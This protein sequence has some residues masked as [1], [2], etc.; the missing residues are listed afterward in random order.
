MNFKIKVKKAALEIL[1]QEV[2]IEYKAIEYQDQ[3]V[4]GMN[5]KIK[6]QTTPM[7]MIRDVGYAGIIQLDVYRNLQ[8]EFNLTDAT[9]LAQQPL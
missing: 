2:F 4:A 5:F 9:N 6:V 8:F 3:V 7:V 1:K